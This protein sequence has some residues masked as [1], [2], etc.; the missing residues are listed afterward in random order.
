M[1]KTINKTNKKPKSKKSTV[2]P[3]KLSTYILQ[4]VAKINSLPKN[5]RESIPFRGFLQNGIIETDEGIFTKSYHLEDV[6]F[7]IA[8]DEEQFSIFSSFMDLLNS[9]SAGMRWQFVIFN[10]EIDKKTV[11]E[12]IRIAPMRDGLNKYRQEANGILLDN[13]KNGNNFIKQD[14]YLV[15]SIED[16]N[17]EH[18]ITEFRRIDAEIS[19]QL[20][21]IC[22][23]DTPPMTIKERIKLLYEIY[24]QD[25]DYRFATGIYNGKEKFDLQYIEKCGLSVKDIIGPSSMDWRGGSKFM[26][27]DTYAQA[28]YLE[29]VPVK[30]KTKF[31]T[32]LS[33]IQSNMLISVTYESIDQEKSIKLVKNQLVSIDAKKAELNRRNGQDG[34]FDALPPELTRAKNNAEDLMSDLTER[35]QNLFYVTFTIVVF[36]KTEE[37][38]EKNVENVK[39]VGS[40]HLCPIKTMKFQQEFCFNTALPLCRN[41]VFVDRLHTTE[42]AATFIPYNSQEINQNGG[43]FY[44][45]NQLTKSMLLYD[46]MTGNNY[47]GLFFGGPGSGKSFTAKWEMI[48]VLLNRPQAQVFVVDPQ[49]EYAPLVNS[50]NGQEIVLAPGNG[51]YLNPLDLDLSEDKDGENDPIAMKSDFLMSM[52][53]IIVGGE[54]EP[55]YRNLLD[56]CIKKIYRPYIEEMNR[57]NIACDLSKCPTLSDLYQELM[58]LKNESYEA[59][60]LA[61]LMYQYAVGSFDT[62]AHRTNVD[63]RKRFIVYNTKALGSGMKE[64]GLHIC[65]NDIW[66]RMAANSKKEMETWF[67]IDEFHV[68]LE[69][70]ATTLF[71][72]RV[73]KMARKWKGVPTGIMQNTEDLLRDADT[74]AI[75][76][77]TEF[78]VMLK[79]LLMDRQNLMELLNLSNAQIKI[80]ENPRKGYGLLYN[81][82]VTLPFGFNFPK[83]TE[84]YKLMTTA[85]DAEETTKK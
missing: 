25:S 80:L 62:F 33:D 3:Q 57:L 11:I 13:L 66:N 12:N 65:T 59:K 50:F 14:K 71:L 68:L 52:F 51:V 10:H 20:R 22:N 30:L 85:H 2:T 43:F 64:L 23:V 83:D 47:N 46:R 15:V 73:W 54:L 82:K 32:D 29:R 9:F 48:N 8:T 34:I 75:I 17:E 26:L 63:T 19:Q 16:R 21:S 74:R 24:N 67:Y 40:K 31:M 76:N 72:K 4:K 35:D 1:P 69:S 42:S 41:D 36:A 70:K 53:E 77:T 44:G 6:N 79:S 60:S 45:L 49:G 28:M 18:A 58:S 27:G 5:V 61:D 37:Q 84:L 81:G 38:L 39:S 55:A 56:K 7:S 78:V